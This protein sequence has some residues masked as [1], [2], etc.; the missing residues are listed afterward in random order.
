MNLLSPFRKTVPGRSRRVSL[1]LYCLRFKKMV[2]SARSLYDLAEDGH[3]KMS[4]DYILDRHYVETLLDGIL[5]HTGRM[6]FDACFLAPSGGGR[7]YSAWDDH[8]ARAL[9]L[10]ET[11]VESSPAPSNSHVECATEPEYLL[12]ASVLDWIGSASEPSTNSLLDFVLQLFEHVAIHV[13]D[14]TTI[15][16]GS[17]RITRATNTWH[18]VI[19]VVA[20]D[21]E[22]SGSGSSSADADMAKTP[23]RLLRLLTGN[24]GA[25]RANRTGQAATRTWLAAGHE[26]RLSIWSLDGRPRFRLEVSFGQAARLDLMFLHVWGHPR[27]AERATGKWRHGPLPEGQ[28][29]VIEGETSSIIWFENDGFPSNNPEQFEN[30]LTSLGTMLFQHG[31][32]S[33]S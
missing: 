25:S 4:G 6:V 7:L 10:M 15:P 21:V 32:A 27:S 1:R 29:A 28:V 11:P 5:E 22:Q 26:R 14:L 17:P 13:P 2:A 31:D 18:N 3:E 12:L 24:T 19:H 20:T 9:R 23:N 16:S 33:K 8:R 30:L